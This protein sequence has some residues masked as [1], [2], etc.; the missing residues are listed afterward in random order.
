MTQESRGAK[1]NDETIPK[2]TVG[3]LVEDPHLGVT[4]R[5]LS[6]QDGL[7]RP[8][9]HPRGCRKTGSLSLATTTAS[10]RRECGFLGQTELS[11]LNALGHDA[12]R[13]FTWLFLPRALVRGGLGR[14][15]HGARS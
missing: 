6:G 13:R 14:A 10:C 4:L 5:R 8:L 2:L 15:T 3:Q 9:N 12:Q 11:Y 7:D 1:P